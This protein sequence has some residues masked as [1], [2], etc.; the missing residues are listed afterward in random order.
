MP[1][2]HRT[3]C[4][5]RAILPS[6]FGDE[7]SAAVDSSYRGNGLQAMVPLPLDQDKGWL[8]VGELQE[9]DRLRTPEGKPVEVLTIQATGKSNHLQPRRRRTAQLPHPNQRRL[10]CPRAQCR[11]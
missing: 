5:T 8:T 9:D 6:E 7:I 1:D 4:P 3:L 2:E 11:D 10:Q